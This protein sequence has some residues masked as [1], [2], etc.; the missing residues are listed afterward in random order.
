MRGILTGLNEAFYLQTPQRNAMVNA[1]PSCE[2]LFK[3]F[4]RGRDIK[5]WRPE[6][7]NQWHI[8]IPS[9]Q[10]RTWPWSQCPDETEAE[11]IFSH[12]YPYV[13][14]HLKRF[15]EAL[16]QRQDKGAFWWE[17]RSCDYYSDFEKSKIVIQCIAY[18]SR[19]AL[20]SDANYINNKAIV[21]PTDDLYVLGVLN[22]RVSWWII[23]R[24]FLHMKDDGL[25]IDVQFLKK[26][27]IPNPPQQLRTEIENVVKE[28]LEKIS[29][30]LYGESIG[31]LELQLNDLAVRAFELSA[32]QHDVILGS[33][34]PRDPISELRREGSLQKVA[35]Q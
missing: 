20:D 7:A 27:P 4:L 30:P 28:I 13:H 21:I 34:P 26:L 3:R 15:E 31:Q 19:F 32:A 29:C 33:L 8:V 12:T 5:R 14:N 2:S 11:A 17:L 9:S 24:T 35:A 18:Y 22:S 23:N 1:D 10:N 25:S 6:W 16:R